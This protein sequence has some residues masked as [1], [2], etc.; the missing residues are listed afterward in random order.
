[1]IRLW[2]AEHFLSSVLLLTIAGL[3]LGIVFA[4]LVAT[5]LAIWNITVSIFLALSGTGVGSG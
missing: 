5:I 1:M 2:M 4:Y 3:L